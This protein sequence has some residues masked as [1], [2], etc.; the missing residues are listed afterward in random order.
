MMVFC[1]VIIIIFRITVMCYRY[2][3]IC[4]R[5]R[6]TVVPIGVL[7]VQYL[8][9]FPVLQWCSSGTVCPRT[10][11]WRSTEVSSTS[12]TPTCHIQQYDEQSDSEG[13]WVSKLW[14]YMC[15][16]LCEF[17]IFLFLIRCTYLIG[18]N[19]AWSGLCQCH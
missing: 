5:L 10:K 2:Y 3:K 6:H 11:V 1:T 18:K 13:Y 4:M 14:S 8:L 7:M 17:E 19:L 16:L 15:L 12:H 9:S